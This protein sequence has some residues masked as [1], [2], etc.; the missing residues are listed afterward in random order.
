MQHCGVHHLDI[1]CDGFRFALI[2][3]SSTADGSEAPISAESILAITFT[4]KACQ[5]IKDRLS[6][7]KLGYKIPVNVFTFHGWAIRFLR[8]KQIRELAGMP[9][10]LII[11]AQRDQKEHMAQACQRARV[12]HQLLPQ[13]RRL[14]DLPATGQISPDEGW[15]ELLRKAFIDPE[16]C[17]DMRTARE[18]AKNRV[19]ATLN[20]IGSAQKDTSIEEEG[21]ETRIDF[22]APRDVNR[23]GAG[24]AKASQ[25][26]QNRNTAEQQYGGALRHHVPACVWLHTCFAVLLRCFGPCLTSC[27]LVGSPNGPAAAPGASTNP[28]AKMHHVQATERALAP[29]GGDPSD[30]DAEEADI[31]NEHLRSDQRLEGGHW[32]DELFPDGSVN[33]W[34]L[35]AK[36][37]LTVRLAHC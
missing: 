28:A 19:Q 5:E 24:T 15:K 31:G 10:K 9:Q 14:M 35:V 16:L 29:A 11:W 26:D 2:P 23:H 17:N 22:A 7:E 21:P 8:M 18:R 4:R 3:P 30:S 33:G 27:P 12:D 13:A 20:E 37:L 1:Q 34:T 25:M 32:I 6:V 36:E